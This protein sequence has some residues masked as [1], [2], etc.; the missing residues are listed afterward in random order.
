M[1][2]HLTN[3]NKKLISNFHLTIQ[4][5][6]FFLV[7]T[8]KKFKRLRNSSRFSIKISVTLCY[9]PNVTK[10]VCS[11]HWKCWTSFFILRF[12]ISNVYLTPIN[13]SNRYVQSFNVKYNE[14]VLLEAAMNFNSLLQPN[15]NCQGWKEGTE[16]NFI[17]PI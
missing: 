5:R 8:L 12:T 16:Y 15:I 9:L 11:V 17:K 6:S 14:T 13:E 2:L 4:H 10:N 3:R 1:S 7:F